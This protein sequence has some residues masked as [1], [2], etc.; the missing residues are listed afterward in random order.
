MTSDVWKQSQYLSDHQFWPHECH[1]ISLILILG[2]SPELRSARHLVWLK[3]MLCEGSMYFPRK[4]RQFDDVHRRHLKCT[5]RWG[6][7]R[8]FCHMLM[9]WQDFGWCL[10]F[11][12][13]KFRRKWDGWYCV[14][15]PGFAMLGVVFSEWFVLLGYAV[16][17][18]GLACV[19]I[20]NRHCFPVQMFQVSEAVFRK[21]SSVNMLTCG[22]KR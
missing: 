19:E 21:A 3:N 10:H 7:C 22:P 16:I 18:W 13:L 9:V 1:Y 15:P 12:R 2:T 20:S 5:L 8:R 14:S 17:F 11:R 4:T 6:A